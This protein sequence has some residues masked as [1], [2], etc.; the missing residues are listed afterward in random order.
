M[1]RKPTVS[2]Y[3]VTTTARFLIQL[4][5][6]VSVRERFWGDHSRA[7]G[8]WQHLFAVNR[9]IRRFVTR[10]VIAIIQNYAAF[11]SFRLYLSLPQ[12][13]MS[14]EWRVRERES[15]NMC[16]SADYSAVD[17]GANRRGVCFGRVCVKYT[18]DG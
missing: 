8:P 15:E 9:L 11:V 17:N 12:T 2:T 5:P 13:L 7:Q 16:R 18:G 1:P 10:R 3:P 6:G 4:H 14:V